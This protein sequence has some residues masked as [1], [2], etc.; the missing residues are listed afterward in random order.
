M[1]PDVCIYHGNCAD[2]FGAAWVVWKKFGDAVQFVPGVYGQDPPSVAGKNVLMVD[3]SYKR[4][5]LEGLLQS[6]DVNQAMTILILDHHKT[7]AEDLA[8]LKAPEGEYDPFRWRAGWEQE[9]EWPVRSVF[10]MTRSGAQIAWDYFNA[11]ARRPS[12]INYIGDRDLW[13]FK[14][15]KSREIAAMLF[16]HPYDFKLWD[17]LS[18]EFDDDSKFWNL[19]AQGEAIERKHHKDIAELIKVTGRY[20]KIGG[21][22]V[23]V[24]NLPY[25]MASDAGHAL[26]KSGLGGSSRAPFA[27]CYF[28]RH[29]WRV[30]S[31]RSLDDGADVSEIAKHY[32]G[33]GHKHAAGFQVPVGWEG[34]A[35]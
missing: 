26:C 30:F 32:G 35:P 14:L 22:I 1:K 34:D 31:L 17:A 11:G 21:V 25:T 3:F 15:T 29:D 8:G 16:S 10:D 7:A 20:M 4:P 9:M 33:G 23:P 28:D 19:V 2:G 6:G 24:A 13:Q 12:M 5:V 27:A 18:Y